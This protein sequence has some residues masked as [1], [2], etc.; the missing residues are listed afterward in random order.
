VQR[1]R[2]YEDT[3][4]TNGFTA[5]EGIPAQKALEAMS[6]PA[7]STEQRLART[8]VDEF[9]KGSDLRMVAKDYKPIIARGGKRQYGYWFLLSKGT[10][11]QGWLR[12]S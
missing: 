12:T 9:L 5:R 11:P 6:N 4:A 3:P 8:A 1:E 7:G 10:E 2:G